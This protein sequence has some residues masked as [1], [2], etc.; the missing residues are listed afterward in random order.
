MRD[1][2]VLPY[3]CGAVIIDALRLLHPASACATI[4]ESGR[5]DGRAA[6]VV[7]L[8]VKML[9]GK[10]PWGSQLIPLEAGELVRM[11]DGRVFVVEYVNASRAR[12]C[13][14][15]PTTRVISVRGR[16]LR[17]VEKEVHE[18]GNPIDISPNSILPIVELGELTNLEF[19]RLEQFVTNGGDFDV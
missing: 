15:T 3:F 14:L 4:W 6:L 10:R 19:A 13:P 7:E 1:S 5:V 2:R 12:V 16:D 17:Y 11:P 18:T 8:G 9:A